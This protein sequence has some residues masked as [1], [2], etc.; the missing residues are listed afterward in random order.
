MIEQIKK[1]FGIFIST[2]VLRCEK[3]TESIKEATKTLVED[4]NLTRKVRLKYL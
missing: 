4:L 2:E 1:V 3:N